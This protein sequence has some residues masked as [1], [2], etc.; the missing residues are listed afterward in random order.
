MKTHWPKALLPGSQNL[1]EVFYSKEVLICLKIK[2]TS[3]NKCN[4]FNVIK[5]SGLMRFRGTECV[6]VSVCVQ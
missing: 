5:L 4:Y 1:I 2:V 6:Y 3:K